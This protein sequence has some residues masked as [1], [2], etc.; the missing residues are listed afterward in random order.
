MAS[1]GLAALAGFA[2]ALAV[3]L[4]RARLRRALPRV[5]PERRRPWRPVDLWQ[6]LCLVGL[7]LGAR[8]FLLES[9]PVD[10]DEPVGLGLA[11]LAEWARASDARLHPP[12]PA[13]L[14]TW[15][16]GAG[17]LTHARSVSVLAG[18]ATVALAYAVVR[19]SASSAAAGLA[20][21][22]L[23]LM[24]AALHTSQLARGYALCAL[25]VLAAHACLS[26]ALAT[27]R[28]RW[29][30]AYSLVAAATLCSEYLALPPLLGSALVAL[31]SVR[32]RASL[33]VGVVGGLGAALT[34]TA[35]LAPVALP[36]LWLGVG[37]GPHA[38]TGVVRALADV[39]GLWSGPAA[40]FNALLALT[41][42]V[43]GTR[44]GA[45]GPSEQRALGALLAAVL[46]LLCASLITAVRARYVL[47]VVPLFACVT[48]VSARGLGR[49]GVVVASFVALGH[50]AL[51][52]AYYAGTASGPEL[53][54]GRRTP[55][56]LALLA[57]H[58]REP[59][60]VVPEWSIAEASWRL[61]KAFPGRDAGVDCPAV[62]CLR[63][64]R[65][66][67]GARLESIPRLLER[68]QHLFVW[69][70]SDAVEEAPACAVVLREAGTTL[71][72]CALAR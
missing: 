12:L 50:A 60:A 59:V 16:G 58:P 36:T 23:A 47:H 32:R 27:G 48:V 69:L 43:A 64:R 3:T 10:N 35:F 13:L 15:V 65:T 54:T 72:T 9:R 63:G 31:A 29:F 41:L 38:P 49:L 70:R 66:L 62:L 1:P 17:E 8:L 46:T 7:S 24:P 20:G 56:T 33:A 68:E 45:L 44:R 22:W 67:Y 25:G 19:A 21:L 30:V 61:E 34:A 40:P 53:S 5:T 71:F 28:E 39:L 52:P 4:V 2:A 11:S 26:R 14:M 55:L 57:A 37:G 42:I 51:V 6:L 18:V